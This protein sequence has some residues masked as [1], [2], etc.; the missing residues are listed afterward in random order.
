MSDAPTDSAS[1]GRDY[2][3]TV[4]LPETPFPMRG[5]LPQKEPLILEQWGDLYGRLRAERQKQKAPAP[6]SSSPGSGPANVASLWRKDAVLAVELPKHGIPRRRQ[7]AR[8]RDRSQ[9]APG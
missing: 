7:S 3:E 8:R 9:P 4:F 1:S 5:G 2:R 6:R